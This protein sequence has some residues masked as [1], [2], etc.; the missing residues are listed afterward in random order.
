MKR[1]DKENQI[2]LKPQQQQKVQ[3]LAN[4]NQNVQ[5]RRRKNQVRRIFTGIK[6]GLKEPPNKTF[7]SGSLVSCYMHSMQMGKKGHQI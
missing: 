2:K 4:H 5:K 3:R 7:N 1:E 6:A